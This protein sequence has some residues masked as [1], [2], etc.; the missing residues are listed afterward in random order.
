MDE[1]LGDSNLICEITYKTSVGLGGEM[2]DSVSNY[3]VWFA[4]NRV[5]AESRYRQLYES[6]TLGEAG[7]TRYTRAESIETGETRVL[8]AGE[9]AVPRSIAPGWRPF[10]D[11]GLTSRSGG[12][13]SSFPVTFRGGSFRPTA[14][15]WRTNPTGMERGIE[16]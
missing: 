4:K 13:T 14:G 10:T 2:L 11:Q 12:A 5:L 16:K 7:A 9:Q 8:S 15:G 1:V 6:L 3:L